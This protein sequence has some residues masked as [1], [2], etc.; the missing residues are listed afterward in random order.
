[1]HNIKGAKASLADLTYLYKEI[2]DHQIDPAQN[3]SSASNLNCC[4]AV[5]LGPIPATITRVR[6]S[7]EYR[8]RQHVA[9]LV[10]LVGLVGLLGELRK[11]EPQQQQSWTHMVSTNEYPD[12]ASIYCQRKH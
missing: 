2:G 4:V 8:G 7:N 3:H 6:V 1:M 11:L 5:A 10:R 9:G 12:S